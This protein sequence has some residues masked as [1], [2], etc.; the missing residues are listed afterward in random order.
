[1]QN[2]LCVDI[3]NTHAV[4]ALMN[5]DTLLDSIRIPSSPLLTT[6]EYLSLIN[7]MLSRPDHVDLSIDDAVI[8]SV[9]PRPY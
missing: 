5:G 7:D 6:S 8:S 4:I 9:V 2:L 3:G 1:M